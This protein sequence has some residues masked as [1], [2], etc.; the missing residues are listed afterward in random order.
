MLPSRIVVV[1]AVL[2][3][4]GSVLTAAQQW[5]SFRGP[6]ASGVF[7]GAKAPTRWDVGASAAVR[8]KATIPG[9]SHASPVV[10]NDRVY[11]VSAIR[12]EGTSAIDRQSQGVVFA[13]DTVRHAWRLYA[14][15]RATGR[16]IWERTAAEGAPQQGR[17]VRGTYANATPATDGRFVCASLGYE[18]LFCF[19]QDGTLRW[20][21]P[22]LPDHKQM[23]DPASSPAI[24]DGLVFVQNDW[25]REG[26]LAAYDLESGKEVW[27]V[28]RS[29]GMTWAS[30]SV[31]GTGA[32]ARLIVNSPLWI[33]ALEPRTG[34]ELWRLDNRVKQPF[35][36]IPTPFAS[37]DL[38]IVAGGGG[39]RPIFAVRAGA[40]GD[41][42]LAE[43]ARTSEGVAWTTERGSPYMATPIAYRG[44]LYA[45]AENGV[46]S[47]FDLTSGARVYQQRIG[48]AGSVYSASPVAADGH[49]YLTSEDGDVTVVRAGREFSQVS[50]NPL[51]D[52]AFATPAVVPGGLIFRTGSQVI[53]IGNG[54]AGL[55][56]G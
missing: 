29:E 34:K 13:A 44:L 18:G 41:I 5:P 56:P 43:G 39:E 17:H 7:D 28:P 10:W 45:I 8:W 4:A 21:T 36:R 6:S 52:V 33:R 22:G 47:A 3:A 42:S 1:S 27:R 48:Q 55:Q 31:V 2:V 51:G 38:T 53:A 26:F 11:V 19:N 12:L 14:L 25:Q 32:A 30:P 46:L 50:V 37:G 54:A 15:D 9:L 35:D 40:T 16:I 23:F 20:R 24:H 49:L